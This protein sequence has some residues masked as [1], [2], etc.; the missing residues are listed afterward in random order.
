MPHCKREKTKHPKEVLPACI[1]RR[2][3]GNSSASEGDFIPASF[4]SNKQHQRQEHGDDQR[5][6]QEG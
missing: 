2:R 5:L 6:Q 4:H 3:L 1:S